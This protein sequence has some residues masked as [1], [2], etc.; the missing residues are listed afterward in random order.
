MSHNHKKIEAFLQY[1]KQKS[2]V[3]SEPMS[4]HDMDIFYTVKDGENF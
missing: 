3:Q 1:S 2:T 4:R